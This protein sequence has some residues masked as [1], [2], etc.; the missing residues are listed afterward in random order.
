M[1]T[2]RSKK[3]LTPRKIK[4]L[5]VLARKIDAEESASIRAR[6][7]AVFARH[8]R[9][10]AILQTLKAR[11]LTQGMS[12]AALAR[13]TGIAKPNLSRLENSDHAAPTLD[14]L[15]RYARAVGM[16]IHVELTSAHA[17]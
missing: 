6:A 3:R 14:T 8:E 5:K 9:L 4:S 2:I 15:E 17:A 1:A 16:T 7:G 13:A 12:L 11:R 10:R